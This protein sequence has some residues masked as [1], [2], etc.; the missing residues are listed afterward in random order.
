MNRFRITGR[1]SNL[2]H[3]FVFDRFPGNRIKVLLEFL[4]EPFFPDANSPTLIEIVPDR[5]V[6]IE[7]DFEPDVCVRQDHIFGFSFIVL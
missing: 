4:A 7:S 6:Y 1:I 3:S 2:G 5:Q